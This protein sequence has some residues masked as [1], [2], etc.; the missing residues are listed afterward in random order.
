MSFDDTV[1]APMH[2]VLFDTFGVDGTVQRGVGAAEPVRI[3]VNRN[4]EALGE[5]G[6]VVGRVTTIEV[7][8]TD[9]W[10]PQEGDVF[11]WTDRLGSHSRKVDKKL[12]DDG[13]VAKVVLHG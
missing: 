7:Q 4:Q 5:H 1:F 10:S 12:E 3:I 11:A 6:Q 13:F 8:V 9:A 2:D